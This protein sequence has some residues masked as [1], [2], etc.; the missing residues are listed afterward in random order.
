MS[1]VTFQYQ[2]TKWKGFTLII[3]FCY[4]CFRIKFSS[5]YS[6]VLSNKIVT[7]Q[8]QLREPIVEEVLRVFC[9]SVGSGQFIK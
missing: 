6:H 8:F 4:I 2:C 3:S 7:L 9:K 1:K 5:K